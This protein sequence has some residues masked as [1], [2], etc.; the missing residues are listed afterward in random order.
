MNISQKIK[1]MAETARR[2]H[3]EY[4]DVERVL[5]KQYP[6]ATISF[7]AKKDKLNNEILSD[8]GQKKRM[9]FDVR[10][11]DGKFEVNYY[12]GTGEFK[13]DI[14]DENDGWLK[15]GAF[16]DGWDF[17]D[18]FKT[19][20]GTLKDGT[21]E[22]FEGATGIVESA[23]DG[24]ATVVGAIGGFFGADDFEDDVADFISKDIIDEEKVAKHITNIG[25]GGLGYAVDKFIDVEDASLLGNKSEGLLN[26]TGQ[27]VGTA[28]LQ[29][30]GVPWW[31]TTGST[32]LGSATEQ[33][34]QNGASFDEAKI[35]GAITAGTDIL[36]EKLFGGSGLGEK[37]LIN[38]DKWTRG[39]TNKAVKALAD[40]GI[41]I[42]TEGGEEVLAKVMT[43]IGEKF[44]YNKD[45][46][47]TLRTLFDEKAL[48]SFISGAV[49][50]GVMNASKAYRSIKEGR[51]Y[52]TGLT[53]NEQKA[54]DSDYRKAIDNAQKNGNKLRQNEKAKIFDG[55]L[56]KIKNENISVDAIKENVKNEIKHERTLKTEIARLEKIPES[57]RTIEQK[58]RLAA[59][60]EQLAKIET[61]TEKNSLLKK[62]KDKV[63]SFVNEEKLPNEHKAEKR[64]GYNNYI[65]P[66]RFVEG[67][68]DDG[69][70]RIK[71]DTAENV[72]NRQL[73]NIEN[74]DESGINKPNVM[75]DVE[76]T[77]KTKL[78]FVDDNGQLTFIPTKAIITNTKI[79]ASI[80]VKNVFRGA[81]KYVDKYGGNESDYCKVAGKIES[82]KYIFDIHFV[83]DKVGNEYDFKI[84]SKTLK[85]FKNDR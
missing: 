50:G 5:R 25:S 64:E 75:D 46:K 30:V 19:A 2:E 7:D 35:Y 28:A 77:L 31:V 76:T 49:L 60:T 8:W 54:F 27:L 42:A 15:A 23:I 59:A 33:A 85:R 82:A 47:I 36:T 38:V 74:V 32:S 43:D 58:R 51:D 63:K 34:L 44:T 6:G 56:E 79:I 9:S 80:D 78:G 20:I 65:D 41:D 81:N 71:N 4:A 24:G 48:D 66:D 18:G 29:S 69:K 37:G 11:D 10:T 39:I 73:E 16:E 40:F 55:I 3:P 13:I 1:A 12:P 83:K 62:V 26:A 52:R 57:Q 61:N 67:L 22:L 70:S 72:E 53:D 68:W 14:D 84:K 21:E 45:K 17:G